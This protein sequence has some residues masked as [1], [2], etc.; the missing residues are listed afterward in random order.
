VRR[1]ELSSERLAARSQAVRVVVMI[2]AK[3]GIEAQPHAAVDQAALEELA[4]R[5]LG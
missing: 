3:V 5:A 2:A 4:R 1:S